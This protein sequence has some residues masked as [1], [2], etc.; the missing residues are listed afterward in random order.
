[1]HRKALKSGADVLRQIEFVLLLSFFPLAFANS[2]NLST[3]SLKGKFFFRH[4]LLTTS[5]TAGS[6]LASSLDGSIVF[7]GSGGYTFQGRQAVGSGAPADFSGSGTYQVQANGFM[8]M[9]NPQR[10]AFNLNARF[11]PSAIVGSSTEAAAA[12]DLFIAIPAPAGAVSNASLVGKYQVAN[13]AV[14]LGASSLVRDAVFSWDASGQGTFNPITVTGHT[15]GS[16]AASITVANGAYTMSP[17]G[18]A[19]ASF[20]I[21]PG[22]TPTSV[23][24]GGNKNLYISADG[25]FV[26]AA[27]RDAGVHD[28]LVG[29]KAATG[30]VTINSLQGAFFTSGIAMAASGFS[31]YVG[32]ANSSGKGTI[33]LTR[34][35][36]SL[37]ATQDFTAATPYTLKADGTGTA[38]ALTLALSAGGSAFLDVAASDSDP[39]TFALDFAVAAPNFALG[40]TSISPFGIVNAGSFAPAGAPLAPG[41]LFTI[42]GN[43][44]VSQNAAAAGFPLPLQLGGAQVLVNGQAVPLISVKADAPQQI[45]A[46]MPASISGA[47]TSIV[48]NNGGRQTNSVDVTLAGEAPGIF[49]ADSSGT[50]A[51]VIVHSDNVTPVS[52]SAPAKRGETI[53]IYATGLGVTTPLVG[54]GVAAPSSP[55]ATINAPVTVLIG[56]KPAGVVFGGLV[57]GFAGLYQL[58]VVI[59]PDAP[60]GSTVPVALSTAESF[61]QQ[62]T[63]TIQ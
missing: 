52:P 30:A 37:T 14:P 45:N 57:A 40:G 38:Q 34:R 58:N 1:M 4:L 60:S 62:A 59:P 39:G 23:L 15:A 41:Q 27:S 44:I 21:P 28:F 31:A 7:D 18:S 8:A 22:Q 56:G 24:F 35:L 10:P 19:I 54:D 13:F 46:I 26:I 55:P 50:G 25:N 32:S 6:A 9:T 48:V 29:F 49:T 51:G 43:G 42:F 12:V 36:H 20:P 5:G 61:N 2:Q 3:A 63:I 53:V 16:P 47:K 11:A 33:L 17:D